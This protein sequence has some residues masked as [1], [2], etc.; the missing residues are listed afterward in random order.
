MSTSYNGIMFVGRKP[1]A[2]ES[3][4]SQM[5]EV[6]LT[7]CMFKLSVIFRKWLLN[8]PAA[9]SGRTSA[10]PALNE[11]GIWSELWTFPVA[12]LMIFNVVFILL[13]DTSIKGL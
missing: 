9:L 11:G 6:S 3:L 5:G 2:C 7:F 13:L 1:L 4:R 10:L 12:F 8:A